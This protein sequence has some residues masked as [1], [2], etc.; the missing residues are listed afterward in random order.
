MKGVSGAVLTMVIALIVAIAAIIVLWLFLS[1][2]VKFVSDAVTG[3]VQ[4]I[5]CWFCDKM[6]LAKWLVGPCGG[7]K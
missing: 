6:G 1:G 3:V 5:L 7:C 2:S 4:G